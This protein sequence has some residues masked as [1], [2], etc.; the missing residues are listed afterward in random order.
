MALADWNP[1]AKPNP[2][3]VSLGF[4]FV[5]RLARDS[6]ILLL[7]PED[8]GKASQE[9]KCLGCFLCCGPEWEFKTKTMAKLYALFCEF[10]TFPCA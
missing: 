9:H 1:V 10:D 6:S 2:N 5:R 7:Q 8:L 3:M 4:A